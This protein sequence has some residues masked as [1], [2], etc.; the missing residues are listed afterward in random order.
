MPYTPTAQ[1]NQVVPDP[2][3]TIDYGKAVNFVQ[4]SFKRF[5]HGKLKS[6]AAEKGFNYPTLI[7]LRNNTL[8]RPAPLQVQKVLKE[9]LFN[10]EVIRISL[11]G[12]S[13][14]EFVFPSVE[15]LDRFH[16]HLQE[17]ENPPPHP[18]T[19]TG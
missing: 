4:L 13:R 10:T 1:F 16:Q 8:R 12:T 7:S 11:G 17:Y 14:Y 3:L 2:K 6:W 5:P 19:T 9:L 18:T 15:D